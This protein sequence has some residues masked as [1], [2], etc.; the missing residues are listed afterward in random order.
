MK[1]FKDVLG[2]SEDNSMLVFAM[3]YIVVTFGSTFWN[4]MSDWSCRPKL[5]LFISTTGMCGVFQLFQLMSLISDPYR[6]PIQIF[7][8]LIWT[9]FQAGMLP[10]M[11]GIAIKKLKSDGH[12]RELFGRQ[13]LFGTLGNSNLT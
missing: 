3:C 7:V 9:F 13:R 10:A 5:M 12:G 2:I 11:D 8:I 6:E 4:Y 1:F